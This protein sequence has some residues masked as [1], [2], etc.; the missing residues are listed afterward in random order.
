MISLRLKIIPQLPIRAS[1][2]L[3]RVTYQ[4]RVNAEGILEGKIDGK[5]ASWEYYG[6][7]AKVVVN[8]D[9]PIERVKGTYFHELIYGGK[10]QKTGTDKGQK[11]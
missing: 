9:F 2:P 10:I 7:K 11:Q 1:C 6:V 8:G 5:W 4:Y 3:D